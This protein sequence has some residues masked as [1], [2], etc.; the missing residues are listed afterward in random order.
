MVIGM[1]GIEEKAPGILV[2]EDVDPLSPFHALFTHGVNVTEAAFRV[3]LRGIE[4]EAAL[5]VEQ[6][7]QRFGTARRI[8]Q[9]RPLVE[10][11]SRDD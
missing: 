9:Y 4:Q 2:I 5:R 1:L 11:E 6:P 7:A 3:V 8:E 10:G